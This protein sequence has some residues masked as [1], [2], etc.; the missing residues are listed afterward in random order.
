MVVPCGE[1]VCQS[2]QWTY[3]IAHLAFREF[4]FYIFSGQK[5]KPVQSGEDLSF[6]VFDAISGYRKMKVVN[7]LPLLRILTKGTASL[8]NEYLSAVVVST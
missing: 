5:S 4:Q 6:L 7:D 2:A 8:L 3:G 1:K